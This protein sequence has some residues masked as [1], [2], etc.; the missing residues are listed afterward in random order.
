VLGDAEFGDNA[1]LR[2]TL[3][4]LKQPHDLGISSTVTAF[5]A[6]PTVAIPGRRRPNAPHPTRLQVTDGSHPEVVR[7]IAA[8]LPARLASRHMAQR[9][10]SSLGRALCRVARHTRDRLGG[11]VAG[12]RTL[13]ALRA[14]SRRHAPHQG[15][16]RR[17]AANRVAASVGPPAHQRCANEQQY[18]ELEDELRLDHLEGRSFPGWHRHVVLTALAYTWLQHER[19][20][21]RARRP[22]L[23]M[24]RAVI[25]EILTAHFL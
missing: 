18:Q 2:W 16:L 8:E 7:T 22:T 14:R 9:N 21:S 1:T 11:H 20:R 17:A 15:L 25:T 3:R 12:A 5:R 13:G 4:R 24:A 6:T 19:R 23:P 10:Q